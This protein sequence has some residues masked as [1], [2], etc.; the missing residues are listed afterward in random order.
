MSDLAQDAVYAALPPEVLDDMKRATVGL[1]GCGGLGSNV[2][3]ALA[4][5]GVPSFVLVDHDVVESSNL[6]RQAFFLQD[7]GQP[8]VKALECYLRGVCPSAHIKTCA[9]RLTEDNAQSVLASCDIWVEAFDAVADKAMLLSVFLSKPRP[10]KFLVCASGLAGLDPIQELRVQALA[11]N[12]VV[13][14]DGYSGVQASGG[15]VAHRV[16]ATAMLQAEAV[17]RLWSEYCSHRPVGP[18]GG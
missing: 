9:E 16:I 10:G 2:A 13:C 14:G 12:V 11:P 17:I 1:A 6:N 3:L 15:L 4:R 18:A 8:K 5:S 7:V